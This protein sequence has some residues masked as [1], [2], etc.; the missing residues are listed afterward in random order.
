MAIFSVILAELRNYATV[1]LLQ[2]MADNGKTASSEKKKKK[3]KRV[4][5]FS[6]DI[7]ITFPCNILYNY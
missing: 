3:E 4:Q 1:L 6:P 2:T 7:R 5:I